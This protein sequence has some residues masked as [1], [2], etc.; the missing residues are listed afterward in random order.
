MEPALQPEHAALEQEIERLAA[1][2]QKS[3]G[4]EKGPEARKEAVREAL[5]R[6]IQAMPSAAP[7]TAAGAAQG[8]AGVLPSYMQDAP[9]AE[10][11]VV[12]KLIDLAWHKGIA[13]AI[14][15]ARKQGPLTLDAFHD[16]L[17]DTVYEEMVKRGHAR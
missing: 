14:G 12:E 5:H 3:S 13:A 7:H 15:E 6:Q 2:A 17:T 9:A 8:P 10:K 4:W 11:L 1:E 16:A